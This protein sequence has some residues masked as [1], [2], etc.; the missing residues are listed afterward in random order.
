VVCGLGVSVVPSLCIPQIEQ[1]GGH[2]RP[3]KA[4]V[5]TRKVGIFTRKRYPLS[6]AATAMIDVL[7]KGEFQLD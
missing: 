7:R 6:A 5:I 2:W 4:P 1:L 3:L